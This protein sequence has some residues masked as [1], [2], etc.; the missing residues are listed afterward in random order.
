MKMTSNST[1]AAVPRGLRIALRVSCIICGIAFRPSITFT[2]IGVATGDPVLVGALL[3]ARFGSETVLGATSSFCKA[4]TLDENRASG[5]A[6][7]SLVGRILV[8]MLAW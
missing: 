4:W 2:G 6:A 8:A 5:P 1:N 7:G 3:P